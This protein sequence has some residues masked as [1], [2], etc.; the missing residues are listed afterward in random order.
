M[1]KCRT[2]DAVPAVGM[3]VS[4]HAANPSMI[5]DIDHI[6]TAMV[7]FVDNMADVAVGICALGPLVVLFT[8]EEVIH[9]EK[10]QLTG[11]A[12]ETLAPTAQREEVRSELEKLQDAFVALE[13]LGNHSVVSPFSRTAASHGVHQMNP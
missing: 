12:R 6:Q 7:T 3:R 2:P 5:I 10:R 8:G 4:I 13:T 9:P 11:I 1:Q